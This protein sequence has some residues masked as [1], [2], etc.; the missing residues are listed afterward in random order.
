VAGT[1]SRLGDLPRVQKL[2]DIAYVW[3]RR[4]HLS[5]TD[6]TESCLSIQGI[7]CA[8]LSIEPFLW[9]PNAVLSAASVESLHPLSAPL[10]HMVPSNIQLVTK[11]LITSPIHLQPHSSREIGG[12]LGAAAEY[13]GNPFLPLLHYNTTRSDPVP[14]SVFALQL[15]ELYTGRRLISL[16]DWG[17]EN[18]C[19]LEGVARDYPR[20]AESFFGGD[21]QRQQSY[22]NGLQ[23]S[24][25]LADH[26]WMGFSSSS[27]SWIGAKVS[28]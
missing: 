3:D 4:L 16:V 13:H 5:V 7:P 28:Q 26:S 22:K 12:A 15:L 2:T 1:A 9:L 25:C 6:W 17:R 20:G 24:L 18:H 14:T 8:S 23:A 19:E 11:L 27:R 10:L 21:S